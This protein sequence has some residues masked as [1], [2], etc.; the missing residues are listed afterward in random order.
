MSKNLITFGTKKDK[1]R[2]SSIE[3]SSE[4]KRPKINISLAQDTESMLDELVPKV[5][6]LENVHKV[7]HL[8]NNEKKVNYLEKLA[9]LMKGRDHGVTDWRDIYSKY[10]RE[11]RRLL[12]EENKVTGCVML[13]YE[14]YIPKGVLGLIQYIQDSWEYQIPLLAHVMPIFKKSE[15]LRD[16]T[17]R[18]VY[19]LDIKYGMRT[20]ERRSQI[21][22]YIILCIVNS[23][24]RKE[25][26]DS[27]KEDSWD[28]L[29]EKVQKMWEKD[30]T[31]KLRKHKVKVYDSHD[32]SKFHWAEKSVF[33]EDDKNFE[34]IWNY[35]V[36]YWIEPYN[37]LKGKHTENPITDEEED[38]FEIVYYDDL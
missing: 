36:E 38:R 13:G 31:K 37:K 14:R 2:K 15:T 20:F 5:N 8:E 23:M 34:N 28:L 25:E 7:N 33:N 1:K 27:L 9:V 32:R 6:Y 26:F 11:Q 24:K 12:I 10:I 16:I 22:Y 17:E 4:N 3:E 21:W 29:K 19:R 35:I 18:N 30:E